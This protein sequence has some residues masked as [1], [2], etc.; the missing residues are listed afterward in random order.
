MPG[1]LCAARKL[2]P[3][4]SL[5]RAPLGPERPGITRGASQSGGTRFFPGFTSAGGN[6]R[7]LRPLWQWS[8]D[9]LPRAREGCT[10]D[11]DSPR[12]PHRDGQPEGVQGGSTKQG[13][14]PCLHPLRAVRAGG[15]LVAP[16]W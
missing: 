7:G 13:I 11:W 15:R 2:T 8:R 14:K 6:P 1:L 10:P 9:R 4:A 16:L 3:V 5:R 12:L